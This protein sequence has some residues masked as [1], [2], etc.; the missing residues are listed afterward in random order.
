MLQ[1]FTVRELSIEADVGEAYVQKILQ[2]RSADFFEALDSV[3]IGRGRPAKQYRVKTEEMERL[4]A[5]LE[6]DH[7]ELSRAIRANPRKQP[8]P[9]HPPSFPSPELVAAED[10][11]LIQF[12]RAKDNEQ[13]YQILERARL[14]LDI[15]KECGRRVPALQERRS[16]AEMVLEVHELEMSLFGKHKAQ[17]GQFVNL[18]IEMLGVLQHALEKADLLPEGLRQEVQ[19]TVIASTRSALERVELPQSLQA[20]LI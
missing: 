3:P 7:E 6:R 18:L 5:A 2:D 16:T 13:R 4:R 20:Q 1:S 9:V 17:A 8:E 10:E 15:E 12:P 14:L 19:Q 11:L